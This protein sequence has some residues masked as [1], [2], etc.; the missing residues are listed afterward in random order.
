[1][2]D[3][4]KVALAR[5]AGKE[6]TPIN[7][8]ASQTVVFDED[9]KILIRIVNASATTARIKFAANGNIGA[10]AGVLNV[11]VAQNKVF[12]VMLESTRF[13]GSNGKITFEILDTDDSSFGGTVT[14]VDVEVVQLP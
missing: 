9:D 12:Y 3:V 1:M 14:D 8:A 10:G 5:N 6:V 7:G 11:D 2:A 13:K 4:A